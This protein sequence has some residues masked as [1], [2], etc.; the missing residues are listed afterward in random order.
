MGSPMKAEIPCGDDISNVPVKAMYQ[1]MCMMGLDK[2]QIPE[3]MRYAFFGISKNFLS[4]GRKPNPTNAR[5]EIESNAGCHYRGFFYM[6]TF[7]NCAFNTAKFL[8]IARWRLK[9]TTWE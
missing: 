2:F 1:T 9:K 6:F 4:I 8:I 3:A 7:F 5:E